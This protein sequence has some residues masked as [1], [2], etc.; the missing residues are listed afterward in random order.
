MFQRKRAIQLLYEF[1]QQNNRDLVWNDQLSFL[2]NY[3]VGRFHIQI[4]VA[5]MQNIIKLEAG[6]LPL[7]GI[8]KQVQDCVIRKF[9]A[10][11]SGDTSMYFALDSG[12]NKLLLVTHIPLNI[13]PEDIIGEYTRARDEIVRRIFDLNRT[14]SYLIS[15]CLN[16]GG[17]RP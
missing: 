16:S 3:R 9:M 1:T 17:G 15:E 14:L 6:W 5:E 4:G 11:N 7:D 8:A 10:E 12:Q 13:D 2:E